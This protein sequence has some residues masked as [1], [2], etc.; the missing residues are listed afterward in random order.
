MVSADLRQVHRLVPVVL[1]RRPG[2]VQQCLHTVNQQGLPCFCSFPSREDTQDEHRQACSPSGH[3]GG[4]RRLH[5]VQTLRL[6]FREKK[7]K[8]KKQFFWGEFEYKDAVKLSSLLTCLSMWAGMSLI[9]ASP[10]LNSAAQ[11]FVKPTQAPSTVPWWTGFYLHHIFE[12][13]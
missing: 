7:E 8:K 11:N 6:R 1:Q 3:G 5:H 12:M 13:N 9:S 4:A 10:L 2:G